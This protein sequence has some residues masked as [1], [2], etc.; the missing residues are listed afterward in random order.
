MLS[1]WAITCS[2]AWPRNQMTRRGDIATVHGSEN[3]RLTEV[4]AGGRPGAA[5]VGSLLIVVAFLCVAVMSAFGKAAAAVPTAVVVLF[6]NGISLLLLLPLVLRHGI[7]ELRTTR[8]PLHVV[9]AISGLLSQA[10][11]FLAVKKM[12]LVDAVLL[13]NAA[14]LFIPFVALVWMKTRITPVVTAGLAI[15]FVGV[16]LILRPSPALLTN[17]AALLAVSAALCSAIALV[18]VNRLSSTDKPDTILFFYFLISTI[19]AFPFAMDGWQT[20]ARTDWRYLIAIGVFMALA[21]LFIILAYQRATA[22][23]LAPFNYSVVVFSGLIGWLVWGN[24]PGPLAIT[25]ILL[26]CAGG[27]ISIVC[28][29][30]ST[31]G[32]P[33]SH[34]HWM[35]Y[36]RKPS[37]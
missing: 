4:M 14:P 24:V 21:Q 36:R 11:F 5:L 28:G 7:G 35:H 20:P 33:I 15:G 29:G 6:Q 32:F 9:R 26:V 8:L 13:V 18:S 25:G 23:R 37:G 31:K 2:N 19:A 17:P 10:L 22:E 1:G 3:Q 30:P 12:A 27:T 34:G 16:L